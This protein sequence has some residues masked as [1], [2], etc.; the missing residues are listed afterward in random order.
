[1]PLASV[2]LITIP[3][4]KNNKFSFHY[5]LYILCRFRSFSRRLFFFLFL[6]PFFFL[7]S[8]FL[9]RFLL[10]S[11]SMPHTSSSSSFLLVYLPFRASIYLIS[12][13]KLHHSISLSFFIFSANKCSTRLLQSSR[14]LKRFPWRVFSK[15]HCKS[16]I[17]A[18]YGERVKL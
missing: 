9:L 4:G 18:E 10:S 12:F 13:K 5:Y 8:I 7:T 11:V 16:E 15:G 6:L 2:K 3:W 1:M 17:T 14:E